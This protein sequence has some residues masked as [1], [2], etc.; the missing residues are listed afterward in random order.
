MKIILDESDL[1]PLIERVV[2]ETLTAIEAEQKRLNGRL[3]YGEAEAASLIGIPK[4][5]LRDLRLSGKAKGVRLGRRIVYERGELL[6][7][8]E[9]VDS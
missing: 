6:R 3:S 1:R 7:L 8:L 4:H 2:R 9:G 5:S